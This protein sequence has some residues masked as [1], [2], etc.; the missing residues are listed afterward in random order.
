MNIRY[1]DMGLENPVAIV[2]FPSSGLV[3]SIAANYYVSQ[4][5]MKVVAGI[6]GPDMPPYC[7]VYEGSAYPPIRMYGYKGRR[8]GGRR[9]GTSSYA[10]RSTPPNRSNATTWRTRS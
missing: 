6:S 5:K 9:A 4:L 10:F 7:F 1:A 2:G 8:G 3:S